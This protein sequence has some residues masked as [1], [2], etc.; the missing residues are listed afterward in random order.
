MTE[1]ASQEREMLMRLSE[2]SGVDR[3]EQVLVDE[4]RD[5]EVGTF[6][7]LTS[8]THLKCC[9]VRALKLGRSLTVC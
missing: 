5:E 2:A 9:I 7:F 8:R 6:L 4:T 1:L 3:D